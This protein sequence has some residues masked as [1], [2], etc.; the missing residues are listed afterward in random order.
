MDAAGWIDISII[1]SFNR[2]KNLTTDQSIVRDT[3]C[4]TPLLEVVDEFVRLRQHWPEWI[5]PNAIPS[6]VTEQRLA[7]AQALGYTPLMHA[8]Q[9][10]MSLQGNEGTENDEVIAREMQGEEDKKGSG[11]TSEVKAVE[12][13]EELDTPS[14]AP[15]PA[16]PAA[17]ATTTIA[18]K[19]EPSTVL[20]VEQEQASSEEGEDDGEGTAATTISTGSQ[21]G[22]AEAEG[23][24][25]AVEA[26]GQQGGGGG[27]GGKKSVEHE[28]ETEVGPIHETTV[29]EDQQQTNKALPVSTAT[30]ATAGAEGKSV[31]F[32]LF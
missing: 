17:I 18:E 8:K 6:R 14:P 19:E 32:P 3:M 9:M 30:A 22:E 15:A 21:A 1:A 2:I 23:E 20:A 4:F 28:I 26:E 31:C 16:V 5:L 27:G 7:E 24:E 13:Q 29:T 10:Q 12:D 25:T 11:A